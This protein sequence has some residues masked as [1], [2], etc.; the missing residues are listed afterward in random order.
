MQ[1]NAIDFP[2][3]CHG[4]PESGSQA[5]SQARERININTLNF[6]G[7]IWYARADSNAR[8][9]APEFAV[10]RLRLASP[11]A[12][13]SARSAG[14][15]EYNRGVM[16]RVGVL[17]VLLAA[18]VRFAPAASFTMVLE[19]RGPK[20]ERAISAMKREFEKIMK[21]SG[22]TFD[23][24]LRGET[25]GADFDNLVLV[26]FDG[27]CAMEPAGYL[28]DERGPLAFT[29]STDGEVQP[30]SKVTCD[31]VTA[32]VRSAMGRADLGRADLLLGRALGRV[33]AHEFVHMVS[34]SDAHGKEGVTRAAISR[35]GLI[36]DEL[37]LSPADFERLR[38]FSR[39]S[40]DK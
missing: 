8:P 10:T 11:P 26:R 12:V 15:K 28:Y 32:S 39:N 3:K 20:S 2:A 16:R 5:R 7:L 31:H 9:F 19:F 34:K 1:Q 14:V 25:D 4:D 35:A 27:S 24:R 23:W 22:L 13:N 38:A 30:F 36:A 21:G 17:L 6:D 37:P 18:I 33:V 29:Y 40:A